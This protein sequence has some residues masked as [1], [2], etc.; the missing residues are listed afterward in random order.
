MRERL[1]KIHALS[2]GWEKAM[3]RTERVKLR[4]LAKK[5]ARVEAE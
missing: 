1:E 3:R 4:K 2:K 5:A